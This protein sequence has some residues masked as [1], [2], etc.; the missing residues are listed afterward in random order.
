VSEPL[1]DGLSKLTP[2]V[3]GN[4][5]I[6]KPAPP[7]SRA[8]II[9]TAVEPWSYAAS[10]TLSSPDELKDGID[11]KLRVVVDF[12]VECGLVGVGCLNADL[13]SYVDR[14]LELPAGSRRKV[15][16]P[17]GERG[18][19]ASLM[20]RNASTKGE[21][22][23][24]RIYGIEFRWVDREEERQERLRRTMS[25]RQ[26]S[27]YEA[28]RPS[29]VFA[30]VSWGAAATQWLAARLNDCPGIYCVHAA[31]L[32]WE[33]MAGAKYLDGV[34]YMQLVG[35]QGRAALAAGDVH[36][37]SRSQISEI[38]EFFGDA[39][40]AAV[41]IR[42]PKTRLQSQL[43]IFESELS[44]QSVDCSYLDALYP[45]VLRNLPTRSYH[46]NLF[47]HGVNMLNA[48]VEEA[49]IAPIFRMEDIVQRPDSLKALVT[50]LTAGTVIPPDD[51]AEASVNVGAT[52]QHRRTER[53][54]W[55]RWQQ[56][57]LRSVVKPE[58][59]TIYRDLG[60]DMEWLLKLEN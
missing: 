15:Y 45:E 1:R 43:A 58:T 56:S 60:Y 5:R 12:Q 55:T 27:M 18:S 19:A 42:D 20:I 17:T 47:V 33:V 23:R 11:E 9:Q 59:V 51:W 22:S 24:V 25:P 44:I 41:L 40:R 57:V 54:P 31:N 32:F 13:T 8:V 49:N 14:E 38:N 37:V 26:L 3:H 21:C 10:F 53:M 48:V 6:I 52:N 46:E 29:R 39:F 36:G 2:I 16:V 30:V 7:D 4:A 50:H 28:Y 34:E 35:M